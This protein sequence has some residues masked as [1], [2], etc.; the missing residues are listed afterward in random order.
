[1]YTIY[2]FNFFNLTQDV[3]NFIIDLS[4]KKEAKKGGRR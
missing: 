2:F 3:L 1:M 4:V